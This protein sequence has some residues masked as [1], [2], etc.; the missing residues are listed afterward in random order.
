MRAALTLLLLVGCEAAA[1]APGDLVLGLRGGAD[2]DPA[3]TAALEETELVVAVLEGNDGAGGR[4]VLGQRCADFFEVL[5]EDSVPT[6]V[7]DLQAALE[8]E[9]QPL[10]DFA[11]GD[12]IG[13]A[14][15][16]RTRADGCFCAQSEGAGEPFCGANDLVC[17]V[18]ELADADADG[19][20]EVTLTQ[21][22]CPERAQE[23]CPP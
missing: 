10:F 12:A 3:F 20:L 9:A 14:V 19:R 5:G 8:S 11:S 17:G 2:D 6:A 7:E 1:P 22:P 21:A 18:A 13:L 23:L 16:G 4:C 15:V